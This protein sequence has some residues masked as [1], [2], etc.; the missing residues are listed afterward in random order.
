MNFVNIFQT[1]LLAPDA[2]QPRFGSKV[3]GLRPGNTFGGPVCKQSININPIF[4][5]PNSFI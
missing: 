4:T 1:K 5:W 2:S 3:Y